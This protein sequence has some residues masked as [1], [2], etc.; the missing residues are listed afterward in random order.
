MEDLDFVP[1]EDDGEKNTP[2]LI[3]ET[4]AVYYTGLPVM[5]QPFTDRILNNQVYLPQVEIMQVSKVS[6]IILD[7][8]GNLV[9]TYSDNPM[10]NT[11][12]YDV[13]FPAGAIKPY[14]AN[15]TAENIHNSVDSDENRSRTFG[16]TLNYCKT[17]NAATIA[18][19]TSVRRNGQI[20]QRKTTSVWNLLIGTKY[21]SEQCYNL[22]YIKESYPF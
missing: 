2:W 20:Y 16:E 17:A 8:Y 14:A 10:P 9:E 22:K 4:E 11:L 12:M 21:G 1:Y 5:Q 3:P 13:E 6:R 18:D 15:M 7:E 19:A